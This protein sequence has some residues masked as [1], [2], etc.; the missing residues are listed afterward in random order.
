[1]NKKTL[2]LV[3]FSPF[4]NTD[5]EL[6]RDN[7]LADDSIVLIDDGCYTLNHQI[8]EELQ[9]SCQQIYVVEQHAIARG[10]T[11]ANHSNGINLAKLNQLIFQ[12]DNSVTW[13]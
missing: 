7:L 8:F 12:Y 2:H 4:I 9:L 5:I 3:R 13:Q 1:M 10:I 6:C 11:L